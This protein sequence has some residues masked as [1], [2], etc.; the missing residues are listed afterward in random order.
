LRADAKQWRIDNARHLKGAWLRFQRYTR[1]NE[2]WGHDHC[3]G[4]WTKFS[5]DQTVEALREGYA[6]TE[7][8]KLGA[9][10]DWVCSTCFNDLKSEM[11]WSVAKSD[12]R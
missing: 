10:Y 6:T 4:C 12:E 8:Y 3:A 1:W 7:D 11:G 9:R 5:D 2:V